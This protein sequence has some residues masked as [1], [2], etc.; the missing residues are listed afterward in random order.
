MCA[1]T[2]ELVP[3]YDS[4]PQTFVPEHLFGPSRL[5]QKATH[6]FYH[7]GPGIFLEL[8]R[9]RALDRDQAYDMR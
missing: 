4:H 3:L 9:S 1:E 2:I 8:P 7:L 5:L 6:R